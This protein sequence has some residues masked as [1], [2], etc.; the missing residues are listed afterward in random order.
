[1]NAFPCHPISFLLALALTA[2]GCSAPEP[3]F[4]P[5]PAANLILISLDTVRPDHLGAYGYP[6]ATSPTIDRLAEAGALFRDAVAVSPW[7]RPSNATLLTGVY[8]LHHGARTF[9]TKLAADV[10][11]LPEILGR[12]GFQ[13]AAIVSSMVINEKSGLDRGFDFF[14]YVSEWQRLPDGRKRSRDPGHRVTREAIRWLDARG[15]SRFFLF[16]HY[17]DAHSDYIAADEF[18]SL[19]V[20]DYDGKVDGSTAQLTAVLRGRRRLDDGDVVHLTALYDAEVR[21]I[22]DE[23]RKLLEYLEQEGLEE[24]TAVVVTSD[25]GEEF[26]EH[27]GVLH[28]R[29]Y[30]RE[31][32]DVPLVMAGPGVPPGWRSDAVASHVD[33]APTLLALAGL[34]VPASMAG[35]DLTRYWGPSPPPAKDRYLFAEADHSNQIPDQYRMVRRA[36]Y[37]LIVDRR[38]GVARLYDLTADPDERHDVGGKHP[39]RVREQLA[40]LRAFEAE[41]KASGGSLDLSREDLE[42]LRE[43]GYAE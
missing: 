19:F 34:P 29:T 38:D 16:L 25:H 30:F 6:K 9:R 4:A 1:M 23:I 14:R 32:I 40:A 18:Q 17:Y 15:E 37:K 22:D 36:N 21:Q 33:I 3:P 7:T 11:S 8:P 27:G 39:E 24:I 28:A 5:G 35:L 42:A 10:P 26:M 12:S 31:V 2:S 43:L 20:T 41:P 13:S